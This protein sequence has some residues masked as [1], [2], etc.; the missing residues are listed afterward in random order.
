[1]NP[2]IQ[3]ILRRV[4]QRYGRDLLRQPSL[5]DAYL[6][7]F[8][9]M[10]P[11]VRRYLVKALQSGIVNQLLPEPDPAKFM[12]LSKQLARITSIDL[13][14]AKDIVGYWAHAVASD[15]SQLHVVPEAPQ[16]SWKMLVGIPLIGLAALTLLGFWLMKQPQTNMDY[17]KV[18]VV[19]GND[20]MTGAKPVFVEMVEVAPAETGNTLRGNATY[21]LASSSSALA[22]IAQATLE[23]TSNTAF[24]QAPENLASNTSTSLPSLADAILP[25]DLASMTPDQL[26][27]FQQVQHTQKLN[28]D[29]LNALQ[30]FVELQ[31]RYEQK[32]QAL[33]TINLMWANTQQPYYKQ[34]QQAMSSQLQHLER[35]LDEN[36]ASYNVSLQ[37]LCAVVNGDNTLL[38]TLAGSPLQSLIKQHASECQANQVLSLSRDQLVQGLHMLQASN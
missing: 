18:P 2:E 26:Q 16:R 11:T 27:R 9:P 22:P 13:D 10:Y 38:A 19:T 34:Q 5:C 30:R 3:A 36:L 31:D 20:L 37:G 24:A 33:Q 35:Q 7:D 32:N 1:M 6:A 15:P 29:A 4:I 21:K 14:N 17:A 12:E 25:N 8:L 28:Q 23:M